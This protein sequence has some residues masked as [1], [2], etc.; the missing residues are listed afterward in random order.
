[1]TFSYK[2]IVSHVAYTQDMENLALLLNSQPYDTW[3]GQLPGLP[4]G[5]RKKRDN[6]KAEIKSQLMKI[7][8]GYC[9]YCGIA[10]NIR[11][12]NSSIHR[13]HIL[14]KN[15]DRY[16][17]FTFEPKN[18][19]LACSR[20]NGFDFKKETDYVTHYDDNYDLIVTSIIHPHLDNLEDHIDGHSS[21]IVEP[22]NNSVK[23]RKTIDEFDLNEEPMI[24]IRGMY[25]L[26]IKTPIS[27]Q[28]EA[29]IAS[30]MNRNYAK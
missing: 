21:V 3:T 9:A 5:S 19:V 2:N 11:G 20:C 12:G 7:Q 15:T 22:V 17:K 25:L 8:N 18:L 26:Y 10:F 1:M 28:D 4:R 27:A 6:L 16:R 14:A 24:S 29:L 13:D 23:G 30:V